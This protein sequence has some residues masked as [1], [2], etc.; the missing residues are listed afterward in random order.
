MPVEA[1]PIITHYDVQ[2][3]RQFSPQ[4]CANW[5]ISLDKEGKR[6]EA[7][8]PCMGRRHIN[9]GGLNR[10][11]FANEPRGLFKSVD[12]G[13]IVEGSNIDIIGNNFSNNKISNSTFTSNSGMVQFDYLPTPSTTFSAFVDGQGMW[14]YDEAAG[15]FQ[16]VTDP[17]MPENPTY[18]IAF[19]NRF[20]VAGRDTTEFRLTQV[21]LGGVFDP[22]TCF[23]VNGGTVFAQEAG[24]IRGFTVLHN[25]LYIFTD[26]TTGLWSNIPSTFNS[27]T[28]PWKKNSSNDWDFGLADPL[29]VDT[30]FGMIVFLAKNRNGLVQVM[31]S[32]GQAPVR[33][34]TKAIDV[35]FE[36]DPVT[37]TLSPFLLGG[38]KGFLYV[39]ENTIFYRLSAGRYTGDQILEISYSAN[40]I[41]FNF[42]AEKWE[43]CIELNGERNRIERHVYF[44]NRHLVSVQQ[45]GTV[46]EM[47]GRF[48]T[49]EIRNSLQVNPQAADA[50]RADPMRYELV[51][52]IISN[53][54]YSEDVYNYVEIDF[55]WGESNNI[56]SLAP[57]QDVQFIV[58]ENED[59]LGEP[60]YIQ[61]EDSP[62]NDPQLLITEESNVV[63]E[64]DI[65]YNTLFKPHIELYWSD[66]AGQMYYPADVRQFSDLGFYRWRMRWYELATSRNRCFKLVCVSNSP[67]VVLGAVVNRKRASG[68]A[69]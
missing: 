53:L 36:R 26:F 62:D 27:T 1:L 11:I 66:N 63:T 47:S 60:I 13:Y 41:E 46:Y 37:D 34:S 50:Y 55:V 10:L 18:I 64:N 16:K 5:Y 17:R 19:G 28:F 3:F 25:T 40:A 61:T 51:T 57:F 38:A 14:V 6:P 31:A 12:H 22:A 52:P 39:Y 43:R 33:I 24:I 67:I 4:D 29:S 23:T 21:N 8:Y 65:T 48:Y 2:R 15:T 59:S 20:A 69:N 7:L 58:A 56:F 68:G 42:D 30:D 54:D 9:T 45:D 35:L 49:N 32:N 44:N